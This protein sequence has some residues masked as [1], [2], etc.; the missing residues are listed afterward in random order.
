MATYSNSFVSPRSPAEVFDYMARFSNA[1][2]WGPGVVE[3]WDL[4]G[5]PPKAGEHVPSSRPVLRPA[6]A[7]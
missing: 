3:A 1:V 2:D 6:G 5:G 7:P 4:S